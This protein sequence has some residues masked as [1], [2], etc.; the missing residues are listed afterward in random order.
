VKDRET[1]AKR[2]HGW[3]VRFLNNVKDQGADAREPERSQMGRT[4]F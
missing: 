1:L 2:R 4:K 3:L